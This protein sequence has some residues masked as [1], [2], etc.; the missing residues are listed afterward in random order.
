MNASDRNIAAAGSHR[1]ELLEELYRRYGTA[2]SSRQARLR[3][4]W[5]RYSWAVVVGGARTLKRLLDVIGSL[6]LLVALSPVFLL[7]AALIKLTDRGPVLFWQKRVGRWGREF[8]FPKFRSMVVN[9]EQLKDKLLEH[10]DHG[11]SVTF[12]MKHDPR[13]TW[14]GR[15]IRR[16]SLDELP[17]LWCVLKGEMSLVGPR[18]PVPREVALYTLSDRRRLDAMPGLTC[19]WQVSGRG[20]IPFPEQVALDVRYIESQSLWLDIKLLFQTSPAVLL[21][22]GAY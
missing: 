12:K 17:Q 13:I 14:I 20:D 9:A 11:Q 4:W 16:G 21:G 6:T 18:P 5:K 3:F 19:I 2:S 15:I 10:N 1:V 7:I 22:K 8:R